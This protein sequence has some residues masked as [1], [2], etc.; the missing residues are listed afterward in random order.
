M[1]TAQAADVR[2]GEPPPGWVGVHGRFVQGAEA[3]APL[4][5]D[6]RQ[7][8]TEWHVGLFTGRYWPLSARGLSIGRRHTSLMSE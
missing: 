3:Q 8:L 7:R 5:L 6:V 4:I 1:P 2:S